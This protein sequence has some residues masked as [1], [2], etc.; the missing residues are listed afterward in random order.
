M[1]TR[2]SRL[3]FMLATATLAAAAPLAAVQARPSPP[4]PWTPA[5]PWSMTVIVDGMPAPE[6]A[7]RGRVYVEALKGRN[8]SLRISNPSSERVAVALSVDG[9]NVIDAKR[10]SAGSATKWILLPGQTADIPG[11]QVSGE[12]S[13]RFFF[14]ETRHSYAKWLGDTANVGTIEAVFFREK[15][16]VPQALQR[17]KLDRW[18]EDRRSANETRAEA[19]LAEAEEG[20][21][22]GVGDDAPAGA[23]D[24]SRE[25][26]SGSAGRNA[27]PAASSPAPGAMEPQM[28]SRKQA[29]ARSEADSFAATG[30]GDRT[31]F[32]VE[33]VSFDEDP[34]PAAR[35][36]L[37]YEFRPE[38]V[39]L[40]VFPR[41]DDLYARDRG[42]GFA[43]E[44]AP[45][46]DR[47]R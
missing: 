1:T 4:N 22:G 15:R 21:A 46:P 47:H 37:R 39:R 34:S 23:P 29:R 14:T 38:L 17:P 27:G 18:S 2:R 40:G 30:I 36:S 31:R 7:S 20:V 28:Q 19:P 35:L 8:F 45:D 10:T 24:S 13:R 26:A 3:L 11:W 9:R 5:A 41:E 43:R 25:R 6:Y 42:R 44:Y 32:E 16:P 12:T 33:W